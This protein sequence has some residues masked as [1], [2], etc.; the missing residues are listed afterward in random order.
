M[1]VGLVVVAV[2]AGLCA[3]LGHRTYEGM[4]ADRQ[5]ALF[6]TVASQA[7]ASLTSVDYRHPETDVQR[8]LELST[9]GLHD[10]FAGRSGPFIDVVKKA[11]SSST[12]TVTE[13]GVESITGAE[14]RVLVAVTVMSS[15]RG[16]PEAQPRNWR[17]RLTVAAVGDGAKV[18]RVEFL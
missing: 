8:I 9:G 12:G 14:G 10:D 7:A 15:N 4:R 17:M 3:A 5:R 2:L 6:V 11:K 13:A 16:V 1:L 18:S